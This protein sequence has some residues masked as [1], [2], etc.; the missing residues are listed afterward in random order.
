MQ[1]R[2]QQLE[3]DLEQQTGSKLGKVYSKAVH[4]HPAYLTYMQSTSCEIPGW[5]NHNLESRLLGES[6]TI[7]HMQMTAP[8]WE[9][10]VWDSQSRDRGLEFS[11]RRKGQT[12]LFFSTFLSLHTAFFF[13]KPRTDDHTTNNSV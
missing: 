12:S 6:S 2:M 13:F 1:V 3:P 8:L 7:S 4:C 9:K 10:G 5:M 11:R